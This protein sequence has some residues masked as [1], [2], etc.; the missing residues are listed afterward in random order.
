MA[1][2]EV[3]DLDDVVDDLDDDPTYELSS[4]QKK[5][6][7]QTKKRQIKPKVSSE[8]SDIEIFKL[9]SCVECVPMLWNARD[10][11]YRNKIE[12][13]SAWK[14]ISENEFDKKFTDNEL[15]AKWSNMR[16]Q[17]RS[18]FAK[19]RKGKF[20]QGANEAVKWEFFDAMDFVGRAEVE[21]T[22]ETVSNLV[23]FYCNFRMFS[24]NLMLHLLLFIKGECRRWWMR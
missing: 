15:M 22:A 19:Y 2:S 11:K 20:G 24:S 14:Q 8:W 10:L 23:C 16:I 18:Y 9:I 1:E 5:K 4:T 7:T 21:Q 17:Y 12:R 3:F 6:V 13:Q